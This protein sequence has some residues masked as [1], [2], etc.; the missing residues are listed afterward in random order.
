MTN[1]NPE[2]YNYNP[3]GSFVTLDKKKSTTSTNS[4]S[5]KSLVNKKTVK[6]NRNT[7]DFIKEMRKKKSE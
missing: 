1:S 7:L 4:N 2:P 3:S 5:V 6:P